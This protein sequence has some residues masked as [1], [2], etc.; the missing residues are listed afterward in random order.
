MLEVGGIEPPSPW[1]ANRDSRQA[2]PTQEYYNIKMAKT[3][4]IFYR[5]KMKKPRC[6]T[7]PARELFHSD[8]IMVS[9]IE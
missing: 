2:T 7:K 5:L 1:L 8:T 4:K 6:G 3:L 9:N